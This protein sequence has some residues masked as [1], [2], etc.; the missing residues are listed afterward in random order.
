M[1]LKDIIK[2]F[3]T[4]RGHKVLWTCSF[5]LLSF[6]VQYFLFTE[7][8]NIGLCLSVASIM[9][10]YY[11]FVTPNEIYISTEM[12]KQQM[13]KMYE[14]GIEITSPQYIFIM[15]NPFQMDFEGGFQQKVEDYISGKQSYENTLSLD[16]PLQE[17]FDKASQQIFEKCTDSDHPDDDKLAKFRSE[18]ILLVSKH[19]VDFAVNDEEIARHSTL[20][21]G[22]KP[23]K[24]EPP[25]F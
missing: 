16:H 14:M 5:L 2:F 25:P 15:I 1:K 19:T 10:L 24:S 21:L 8:H 6:F 4:A 11:S 3:K 9:C 17:E 23:I 22:D 20:L 7:F 13:Q 12:V 18:Y